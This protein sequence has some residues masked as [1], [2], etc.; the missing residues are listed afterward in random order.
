[1]Q[2]CFFLCYIGVLML[3][4]TCCM[5]MEKW[6]GTVLDINS[7]VSRLGSTCSGN[8]GIYYMHSVCHTVSYLIEKGK[9]SPLKVL[10]QNIVTGLDS[11]LGEMDASEE[12]LMA[13]ATTFFLALYSQKNCN[14][15]DASRCAIFRKRKQSRDIRSIQESHCIGIAHGCYELQM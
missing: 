11:V 12:D 13:T 1:M 2:T 8:L 3:I 6:D 10:Y 7:T 14:S 9:V 4:V 15:T 5:Q